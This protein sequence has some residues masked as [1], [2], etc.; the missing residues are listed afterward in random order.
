MITYKQYAP[1]RFDIKGLNLLDNQNWLVCPVNK[2]RDSDALDRSNFDKIE[3]LLV[4]NDPNETE[5]TIASFNHWACGWFYLILVNP[6]SK[7]E[8]IVN[9]AIER[10]ENYPILDEDL[11]SEYELKDNE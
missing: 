6:S 9:N 10:L 11:F 4:D 8:E 1:T 5:H 3:R 2:T 7:S